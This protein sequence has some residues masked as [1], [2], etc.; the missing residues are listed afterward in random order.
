MINAMIYVFCLSK[1][2]CYYVIVSKG[3]L[4]AR[5]IFF[6]LKNSFLYPET[7]AYCGSFGF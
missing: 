1:N 2:V 4:L 3:Y 6:Y 5:F 7:A